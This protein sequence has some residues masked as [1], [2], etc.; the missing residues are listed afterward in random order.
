MGLPHQ[1]WLLRRDLSSASSGSLM[2]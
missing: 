2:S 1:R